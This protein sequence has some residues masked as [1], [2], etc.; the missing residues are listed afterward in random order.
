MFVFDKITQLVNT[1]NVFLA[2]LHNDETC[3]S[4]FRLLSISTP[5]IFFPISQ[6]FVC[7]ILSQIFSCLC[8]E[9]KEVTFLDSVSYDYFQTI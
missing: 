7:P 3:K 2:F 6:I 9:T 5:S 8:P 1:D 4:S